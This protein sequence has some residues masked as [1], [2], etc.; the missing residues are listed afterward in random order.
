MFQR[1]GEREAAGLQSLIT[2]QYT[3][4][5]GNMNVNDLVMK[6]PG[7]EWGA[8]A[9]SQMLLTF[10]WCRP[11]VLKDY[12]FHNNTEPAEA[13]VRKFFQVHLEYTAPVT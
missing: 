1:K 7:Q 11:S 13:S 3:K 9:H 10:S 5:G 4:R 12:D 2:P 6:E 8:P